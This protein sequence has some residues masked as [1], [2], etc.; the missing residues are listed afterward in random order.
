MAQDIPLTYKQLDSL[1][2]N[3]DVPTLETVGKKYIL[4]SDIHLGNGSDADD[5]YHNQPALLNALDFYLTEG[6]TLIL[7]GDI[8]EFWQFDLAD[9]IKTYGNTVYAKI[10]AFGDSRIYRVFGNHDHE[11]AMPHDPI[12]QKIVSAAAPA[13]EAIKLRDGNGKVRFLLV[14]GHQ[15]SLDSDKYAWFSKFFV[16]LYGGIE[17]ILKFTGLFR[18]GAAT[19]SSI[20]RDYE[21]ILYTWARQK[22][23]ILICGH[24]HRALFA[25]RT[26]AEQLEDEIA[27]RVTRAQADLPPA[28]RKRLLREIEQRE[29]DLADERQKGREI[30]P[31]EP[32]ARPRPNY[33]NTGCALYTDGVTAI[34]IDDDSIR[35]VK[36][37]AKWSKMVSSGQPR[38]VFKEGKVSKFVKEIDAP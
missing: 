35:L 22:R 2:G 3:P 17:P 18:A 32:N 38:Q 31:L 28:T 6:Y 21:R 1:W 16:R 20:A 37:S 36:W 33:F 24:S 29:A 14:H 26:F 23:I 12:R 8:E 10:R 13:E 5:F 11:W 15:G 25:S 34:E 9:T 4:F 30:D 7:L 19:K 27:E